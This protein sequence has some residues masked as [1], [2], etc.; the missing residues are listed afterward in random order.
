MPTDQVGTGALALSSTTGIVGIMSIADLM[1]SITVGIL[2][3]IGLVYSICW[4]RARIRNLQ[5]RHDEESN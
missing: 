1:L 3:V 5:E 2:S 4:H